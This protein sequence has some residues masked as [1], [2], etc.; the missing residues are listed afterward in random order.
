[1][2]DITELDN[3]GKDRTNQR[4]EAEQAERAEEDETSFIENDAG[5]DNI[6]TQISSE[7]ATQSETRVDLN[8]FDYTDVSR[9]IQRLEERKAIQRYNAIEALES[10]T[11]TRF[12][13]THGDS[14]KELIDYV[15]DIKYS[16]G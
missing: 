6:R 9:Q 15:S 4:E 10:A 2:D 11:G 16:E 12:S 8:D 14:S 13:V 1:M 5:Y 3:I 7:S